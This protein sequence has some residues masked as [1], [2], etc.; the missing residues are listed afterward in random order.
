MQ[1]DP[2]ERNDHECSRSNVLHLMKAAQAEQ[3]HKYPSASTKTVRTRR[4]VAQ[5]KIKSGFKAFSEVIY[6]YS[7]IMDVLIQ[8]APEYVSLVWGA[9][10]IILVVQINHQELKLKVK[11]YMEHIKI[12]FEIIDHLTAYM[13]KANL[14][15][16]VAKAYELFSRFL[17]KAV[18]Y[19]SL[20]RLSKYFIV[21]KLELTLTCCFP[22]A[23][24]RAFSR[25]WNIRLQGL[26]DEIDATFASI[27]D[28]SR[29]HGLV[30]G[31]ISLVVGQESLQ[32]S[33][34]SI[35]M[36]EQSLARLSSL[37]DLIQEIHATMVRFSKERDIQE[38]AN[39][40]Q[41]CVDENLQTPEQLGASP[42]TKV[43]GEQATYDKASAFQRPPTLFSK[44]F[45]VLYSSELIPRSS[46]CLAEVMLT[47]NFLAIRP[48][49]IFNELH[50]S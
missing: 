23:T 15:V 38:T 37:E 49:C 40:L 4:Q 7:K 19:Y 35:A 16:S 46:F 47:E 22:E 48:D 27:D 25:P 18:K 30:E 43:P 12:R 39:L 8:Q 34:R 1:A 36:H 26:V 9:I 5:A 28:I 33:Q 31:H 41:Q 50:R 29:Y 13:P 42:A 14:V 10:K 21:L 3:E 20:N 17:A 24:W 44:T 6:E 32:N 45:Q 11:E 2:T